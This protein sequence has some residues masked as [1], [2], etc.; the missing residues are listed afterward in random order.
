MSTI[1]ELGKDLTSISLLIVGDEV[2]LGSYGTGNWL[3]IDYIIMGCPK[4]KSL[5]LESLR[6]WKQFCS[7][8]ET[9]FF[10]LPGGGWE[11]I[12]EKESLEELHKRCKEL[13]DLKLTKVSFIDIFTEDEIT[14]IFPDCNVEIKNCEFADLCPDSSEDSSDSDDGWVCYSDQYDSDDGWCDYYIKYASSDDEEQDSNSEG[15]YESDETNDTLDN[16]DG[17]EIELMFSENYGEDNK[18]ENKD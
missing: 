13:K 5:T 1:M 12:I 16:F 2:G 10:D 17:G 3:M 8:A 4:L 18:V 9:N 7:K 14:N 11:L 15:T 6:G